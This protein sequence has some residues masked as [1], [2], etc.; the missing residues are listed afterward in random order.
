[1]QFNI[2]A[3]GMNNEPWDLALTV[4]GVSYRVREV[5]LEEFGN[6]A[7]RGGLSNPDEDRAI[8]QGLF[9]GDLVPD[10]AKWTADQRND[11]YA[12]I[13]EYL[14]LYLEKKRDRIRQQVR[15][16]ATQARSTSG[17]S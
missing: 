9:V 7:G 5:T 11:A 13:T 12:V 2:D 16:A 8:L 3:A 4:G 1:M 6:M 17:S 10:L 14:N 15:A